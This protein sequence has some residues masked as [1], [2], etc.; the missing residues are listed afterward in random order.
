MTIVTSTRS[1]LNPMHTPTR[2]TLWL[3]ITLALSCGSAFGATIYVDVSN[4][5][6]FED[7]TQENPYR[8]IQAGIDATTGA[9]DVVSVLPGTY[10][11][12]IRMQDHI[13]VRCSDAPLCVIDASGRNR[14]A[15]SFPDTKNYPSI[16]G[17]TITGGTGDWTGSLLDGTRIY[18]GGGVRIEGAAVVLNNVIEYNVMYDG[19]CHGAG[20]AISPKRYKPQIIGNTIRF[21]DA[22]CPANLPES[23]GGGIYV[24]QKFSVTII[25]DNVIESNSANTGG[26]IYAVNL[27]QS[28]F[29]IQ[30]NVFQF[31]QAVEGAA[32]Y[33]AD[34][35]GTATTIASNMFY[36]NGSA[37]GTIDC[38]DSDPTTGPSLPEI[39]GDGADNDCDPSTPD[40]FDGDGDGYACGVDCDDTDPSISPVAYEHCADGVDNNCDGLTDGEEA[41]C[42]CDDL[43]G[44]GFSCDDCDDT[45]A[46]SYPTA[47][48]I[49]NDGRDNDCNP[50]TDDLMDA[51]GDLFN[52]AIDCDDSDAAINPD[53]TEVNCD[54]IDNDCNPSTPDV[55]D[56]D[57]DLYNCFDDCDDYNFLINPS[58]FEF[59]E[60]GVDNNCDGFIDGEDFAC[61]CPDPADLDGDGYRCDDC[62]DTDATIH[63]AA[64]E[65]C[66]DGLDNDC[67]PTTPD[68][69]DGDGDGYTCD[70]EC[71]DFD[72]AVNPAAFEVCGDT[73]DNDCDGL[74]DGADPD[75]SCPDTDGDGYSCLDCNDGNPSIN[76][77]AAEVCNDGIDN[78]CDAAT[79]DLPD[80]D[81]DGFD[82]LTDCDD[83]DP[84]IYPDAPE[85]CR[86]KMD[87]DCDGLID[88]VVPDLTLVEFGSAMTYLANLT[89]PGLGLSWVQPAFDESTWTNGIFGVG[90]QRGGGGAHALIITDVAS[91]TASVYT[92]TRFDIGDPAGVNQMLLGADWDDGYVAWINGVEV[93]RSPQIPAGTPTWDVSPASHESSNGQAP[94]YGTLIDITS[95]AIPALVPGENLLAV[96]VYNDIP[97][98]GTSS[99]LVV[100]PL[101]KMSYGG[102]DPDC[103][104][105][106]DDDGDGYACD[107]CDDTNLQ[108]NP[109]IV[110]VGCNLL[111]DDCDPSTVDDE[112]DADADGFTCDQD[113][114]ES[115]PQVNPDAPE[116]GC[117]GFDDDCNEGTSDILDADNDGID[118]ALDC[119]DEDPSRTPGNVEIPCDE[120]DND[121]N[122]LTSDAVDG[123]GDGFTCAVECDDTDP[124]VHPDAAE[125]C[126]D[127]I[128]N[129]CD[130]L[131][132]IEDDECAC[133]D[134]DGDGYAC[135]DCDDANTAVNPGTP[136]VCDDGLDNDCDETTL[137]IGDVDGDGADCL[138]D[139]DDSNPFVRPGTL[140]LCDDSIDNDCNPGTPDIFDLDADGYTCVVDCRDDIAAINPGATELCSDGT[141]NDCDPATT[142]VFDGDAD[143]YGCDF[144]CDDADGGVNPGASEVCNDGIDN[145][146]NP[147]TTDLFDGDGDGSTCADDC[148]DADAAAYPGGNERCDDGIDNDCDG[149]TD[150]A[151]PDCTCGDGDGDGFDCAVDCNDG[152]A[153]INPDAAEVCDDGIDN[154]CNPAT[155]D[156]GDLDGDGYTCDVDCNDTDPSISPGA[157]EVCSDAID[158]DCNALTPDLFDLDEDTYLCDV[159]CNDSDPTMNPGAEEVTC[160]QLD[161]DCNMA[162]L[163][164]GDGDGDSVGCADQSVRGGGIASVVTGDGVLTVVNNTFVQNGMPLGIGGAIW[165]DGIYSTVPGLLANNIIVANEAIVGGGVDHTLYDG[166]IASNNLFA[167]VG[168]NLYN[169]GGSMATKTTNTFI[170]PSFSASSMGNYHLAKGSPLIDAANATVAPL[171]DV[172]GFTRPFDGDEDLVAIADLGAFEYPSGEVFNLVFQNDD[173]ISWDV[174]AGETL[175]NVYRGDLSNILTGGYTQNPARQIPDQF[176]GVQSIAMPFADPYVPGPGKVVY[177]LVTLTNSR[178]TYEGTLGEASNGSLRLGSYPCK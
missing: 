145:D 83:S 13:A 147:T 160:D 129:D 165:I 89:D 135:G 121:C 175:F 31:N 56:V 169:G 112:V 25:T 61:S 48:E 1:E 42:L 22:L 52:C 157:P 44:D 151:D 38:D 64:I 73:L 54:A 27:G 92:R 71:R 26:G 18:V 143:T 77:G 5:G 110:E 134:L 33:T 158:N 115:F 34:S 128:D 172:D 163:D 21:N 14:S 177:Y 81:A 103:T 23:R 97:A 67:M 114:N 90:Y 95:V 124:M 100:V 19:V 153:S 32:I 155:V 11:E 132:D 170:D 118:C 146:C 59:C 167:N 178:K 68:I 82:C 75:C 10:S 6:G 72:P 69:F 85:A 111:D 105:C 150:G 46:S 94:D 49:C 35:L 80:A 122:T 87:N 45:D 148:D 63:P 8:S 88:I 176:C 106:P 84:E 140:E 57:S 141:D 30:R 78:D 139:C 138:S 58:R 162:T 117:N 133:A 41:V 164:L 3:L 16:E 50:A 99:D 173:N 104:T 28:S 55:V 113:C 123:D 47:V 166:D 66:N 131:T 98:V 161:N 53:A 101:L 168:G 93:Y 76:P 171:S 74:V 60:D 144:D 108:I 130:D 152:D 142:D 24:S 120:I 2:R 137:D 96:G 154:D 116:V 40:V 79:P 12:A 174:R 36:G 43:D 125:K 9:G 91:P 107:D 20:I 70:L 119:D 136:E 37:E 62:D 17:F 15:V 29:V 7:G 127:A 126:D 4:T 156:L 102:D 159:D 86:D 65:V 51:D 39:C 109:S 149:L